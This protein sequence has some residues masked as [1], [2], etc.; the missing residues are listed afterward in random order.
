MG[1][2]LRERMHQLI[3]PIMKIGLIVNWRDIDKC[4]LVLL[5]GGLDIL[6]W[7]IWWWISG[8]NSDL[9]IWINLD[10]Y[11]TLMTAYSLLAF[12]FLILILLTKLLYRNPIYNKLVPYITIAYFGSSFIFG[13]FCVGILSPATIAGYVSL[14]TVALVLFERK[15][16]YA[17][18]LPITSFILICISMSLAGTLEY[19]PIF[20]QQLQSMPLYKNSFWVYSM[21]YFYA[22]IFFI[23]IVLFETLLIQWRE[24]EKAIQQ[25]SIIDSLTGIFNRRKMGELFESLKEQQGAFAIILL[26]LDHF[27]VINDTYGHDIGDIVLKR[28]ARLLTENIDTEDTVGRFGGEE[29]IIF[30]KSDRLAD[31]ILVA[32]QC[33][34]AIASEIIYLDHQQKLQ[35]SASFGITVARYPIHSKEEVVRQADQALYLAKRNGRNQV[36]HFFEIK[37]IVPKER[38]QTI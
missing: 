4:F 9:H 30:L 20:S 1:L 29:F 28:V 18:V 15:V 36:R 13:G 19:S 3:A 33:R 22:P 11:P 8:S 23:S 17:T 38:R 12:G 14:V 2:N 37:T 21:V 34:E 32:E 31:A 7:I 27:K 6:S 26:D 25:A 24:R 5:L 16:V 35:V 10:F